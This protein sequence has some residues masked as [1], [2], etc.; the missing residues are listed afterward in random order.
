MEPAA[1][2][3]TIL[4]LDQGFLL[5]C[6]PQRETE[7][8]SGRRRSH[9]VPYFPEPLLPVNKAATGQMIFT[10]WLGNEEGLW[11]KGDPKQKET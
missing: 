4:G 8:G 5:L 3:H 10:S 9:Q 7:P 6:Y 11:G 1:A 2:D